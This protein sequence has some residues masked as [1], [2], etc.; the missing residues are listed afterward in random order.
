MNNMKA[1]TP[2]PP[3]QL[4]NMLVMTNSEVP[5]RW[6]MSRMNATSERNVKKIQSSIHAW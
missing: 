3:K 2:T 6:L 5:S 4:G 1:P